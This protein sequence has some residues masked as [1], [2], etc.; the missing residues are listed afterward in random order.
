MR[1][2][3]SSKLKSQLVLVNRESKEIQ[4]MVSYKIGTKVLNQ[5]KEITIFYLWFRF[6][7]YPHFELPRVPA[8]KKKKKKKKTTW[9]VE[10]EFD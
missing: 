7:L 4:Y 6:D 8:P 1:V 3:I 2:V 9:E 10:N 5:N